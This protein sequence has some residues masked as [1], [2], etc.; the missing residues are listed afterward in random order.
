DADEII[1]ALRRGELDLNINLMYVS[2][3]EGLCY[4]R[5]YEEEFVVCAS[6]DHPLSRQSHVR[7]EELSD[8]RWAQSEPAL[9]TQQKLRLVFE[10]HGLPRPQ[11]AL[12]CRSLSVR[13][14]AVVS[15]GLLAY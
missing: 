3:P 6:R 8:A 12:E 14:Q 9:P 4:V 1:P 15:S 5:L 13:L 11:A 2:P 10:E 7:L